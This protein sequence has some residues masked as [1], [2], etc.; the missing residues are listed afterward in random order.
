MALVFVLAGCLTIVIQAL[1]F[2]L[3]SLRLADSLLPDAI[4]D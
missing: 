3:P 2:R 4:P 1:A